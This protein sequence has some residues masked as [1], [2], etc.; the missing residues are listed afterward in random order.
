MSF[1][2]RLSMYK[3][4]ALYAGMYPPVEISRLLL[5]FFCSF[6]PTNCSSG[7]GSMLNFSMSRAYYDILFIQNYISDLLASSILSIIYILDKQKDAKSSVEYRFHSRPACFK[8]AAIKC[9]SAVVF[10][11]AR[12]SVYSLYVS[13]SLFV[14]MHTGG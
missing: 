1:K 2:W 12:L 7:R 8:L 9:I 13:S 6:E 5:S 4:I 14:Q 3:T 10:S 11:S